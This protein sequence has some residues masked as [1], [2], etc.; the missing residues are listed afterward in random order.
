M[1][2]Q[3][4]LIG[5]LVVEDGKVAG[6]VASVTPVS[7]DCYTYTMA[8]MGLGAPRYPKLTRDRR[9]R[10]RQVRSQRPRA[11]RRAVARG[12]DPKLAKHE[13]AQHAAL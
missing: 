2:S 13:Y 9:R 5:A 6:V 12:A 11:L 10:S 1:D 3:T 4:N 7:A 8:P